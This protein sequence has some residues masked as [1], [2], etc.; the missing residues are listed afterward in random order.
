MTLTL[1]LILLMASVLTFAWV[2]RKIR[3]AQ[4][5]LKDA[6]FWIISATALVIMGVFPQIV[7]WAS[8]LAGVLSPVNFVFLCIIFVLLIKVFLLSI[9]VSQLEYKLQSLTQHL[10]IYEKEQEKKDGLSH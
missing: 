6:V 4:V 10:A 5:V 9:S 7:T 1:R 8:E 2:F 3:K